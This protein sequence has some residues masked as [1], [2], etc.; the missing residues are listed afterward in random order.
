MA[1]TIIQDLSRFKM[2]DGFRGKPGWYVQ[3][4]WIVQGTLFALSPQFLY[5][6]RRWLLR[7]FGAKVG[8][9][10]IIRP[11]VRFQ[12]PWKVTLGENAWIGDDV[13]LYSLGP[14][15]VGDNAVVSQR[16]Y[17]CT[18][19]HDPGLPEFPIWQQPII[20]ESECWIA[21]DVYVGPGVTIGQG[22]IVGARS[23]VFKSLP[24][25]KVCVGSPARP[26]RDRQ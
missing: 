24:P 2:P 18:G 17:L 11:T 26:V 14:I 13:I 1:K 7:L 21:T 20:I 3:L 25:M 5:G 16:S 4:W 23:S 22:T 19:S 10:A 6:Y 15:S 8:K 9:G 12:F